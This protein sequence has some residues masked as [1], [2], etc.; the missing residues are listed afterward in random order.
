MDA[1]KESQVDVIFIRLKAR[2]QPNIEFT[3]ARAL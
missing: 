1:A 3:L 2:L